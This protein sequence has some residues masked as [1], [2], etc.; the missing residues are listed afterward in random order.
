MAGTTKHPSSKFSTNNVLRP[1]S[2]PNSQSGVFCPYYV[3]AANKSLN[4]AEH[5]SRIVLAMF[6]PSTF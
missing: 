1:V 2:E 6:W 5:V 4:D 3:T